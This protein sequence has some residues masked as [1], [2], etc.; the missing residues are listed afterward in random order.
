[1]AAQ[2]AV[3][4]VNGTVK[5]GFEGF[6]P[7]AVK[8][9]RGPFAGTVLTRFF[10]NRRR[11]QHTRHEDSAQNPLEDSFLHRFPPSALAGNRVLHPPRNLAVTDIPLR[12]R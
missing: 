3:I 9:S 11:K 4:A 10:L 7:V 8:A 12:S 5:S 6:A 1:M 2:T